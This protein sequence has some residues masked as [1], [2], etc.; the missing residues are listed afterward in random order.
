MT[1]GAVTSSVPPGFSMRAHSRTT[2]AT[3]STSWSVCVRMM[4]S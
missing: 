4:Q 2:A 1:L 3:S